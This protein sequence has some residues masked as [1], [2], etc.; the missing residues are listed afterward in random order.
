MRAQPLI[1]NPDAPGVLDIRL[2]TSDDRMKSNVVLQNGS[3]W[4]VQDVNVDGNAALRWYEIDASDYSLKQEG[5][6]FDEDFDFTFG[7]IAVNEANDVVIGFNGSGLSFPEAG[8]FAS[9]FAVL[10]T[11]VNGE[12]VFEGP[13]LLQPGTAPTLGS[14]RRKPGVP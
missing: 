7:S 13:F 3:L 12:T 9:S 4:G 8:R 14:G 1:R 10:G 11:E 6:I 5:L 2:E